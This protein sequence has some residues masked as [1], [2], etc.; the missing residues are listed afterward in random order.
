MKV[1][2]S[3]NAVAM[4]VIAAL[5]SACGAPASSDNR[6][7]ESMATAQQAPSASEKLGTQWGDD[8]SSSVTKVDLRRRSEQPIDESVLHYAAKS[9]Q[10]RELNSIALAN[11]KIEWSVQ[12]DRNA[13]LP[14]FRDGGQYYLRGTNGQ[15]YQLVYRNRSD[16]IYEIVASVDGLDVLNGKAASRYHTGYVL[17]PHDTLVIEGFRKSSDA[18]AS[19]IFSAPSGSYAANS[20]VG[21]VR[22]VGLIGTAVFELYDPNGQVESGSAFPA[23]NG[24]AKPPK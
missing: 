15:A 18:V 23:D 12:S 20:D 8:V 14:L 13:L 16:K 19:F 9:F 21:S 24:Y 2:R 11:G 7:S 17:R 22:N 4:L 1:T 6:S 10:G 3:M 5:L